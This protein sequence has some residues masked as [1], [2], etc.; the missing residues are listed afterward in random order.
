MNYFGRVN[1]AFKQKYLAEFVWRYDGSYMF[2]KGEQFGF[3]PGV[4]LGWRVSEEDFWKNNISAV[5]NFKLRA[6]WGQTGNDRIAEY[7]Y[8]SSYSI[9][10]GKS[11]VFNVNQDNKMLYESRIPNPNV[12][13]EVANKSD[14]GFET[15]LFN[16]LTFEA[17]YFY[18][19]RTNRLFG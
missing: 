14:I 19:L 9:L 8:L 17:D 18:N 12:T 2:P 3:F 11:Y 5:N 1:Y 7:Q 15:M 4:S 16:R 13:W 6:S 10:A